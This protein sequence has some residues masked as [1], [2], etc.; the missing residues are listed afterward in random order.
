MQ[1]AL[2]LSI[3]FLNALQKVALFTFRTIFSD[4]LLHFR[5]YLALSRI[6]VRYLLPFSAPLLSID[7]N[8]L[9]FHTQ[10]LAPKEL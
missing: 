4:L 10:L 9:T 6:T 8:T 1:L 2:M 5:S 3:Y 7:Q